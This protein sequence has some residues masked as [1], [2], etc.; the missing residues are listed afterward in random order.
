[1]SLRLQA[2]SFKSQSWAICQNATTS[3]GSSNAS[4]LPQVSLCVYSRRG[5]PRPNQTLKPRTQAGTRKEV[6]MHLVQDL[7]NFFIGLFLHKSA[8]ALVGFVKKWLLRSHISK[9]D[10]PAVRRRSRHSKTTLTASSDRASR[11]RLS[12]FFKP[13]VAAHHAWIPQRDRRLTDGW[14]M[15]LLDPGLV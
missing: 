13:G 1:M 7:F 6:L 4:Y 9:S 15:R 3:R 12:R 5:T 11:R 2:H 8:I 10:A 14:R